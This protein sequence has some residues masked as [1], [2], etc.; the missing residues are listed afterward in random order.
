ML[1]TPSF[2]T[3]ARMM[4]APLLNCVIDDSLLEALPDIDQALLQFIKVMIFCSVAF[5]QILYTTS[6]GSDLC[7]WG[8]KVW[9]NECRS[10]DLAPE[11]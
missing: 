9:L 7:Y 11:D 3:N 5:P 4:F 2:Y 8:P 6:P 10:L 1:K